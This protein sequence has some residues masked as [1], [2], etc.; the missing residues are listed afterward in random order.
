MTVATIALFLASAIGIAAAW[1]ACFQRVPWRI[2]GLF[3]VLVSAYE[4]TTL[5]TS[6]VD[7]PA[8][9]AF[10]AYPWAAMGKQP[11]LAN[12]GIVF[13]QIAPWTRVAR[14]A[15]LSGEWPLWN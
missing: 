10:A 13:T 7:L 8:D 5:F 14:D 1:N 3:V 12:T 2:V 9:L 4:A 11:A 6:R 15:I